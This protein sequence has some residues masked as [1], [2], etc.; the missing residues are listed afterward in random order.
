VVK[1]I[2]YCYFSTSGPRTSS[3]LQLWPFAIKSLD[4]HDYFAWWQASTQEWVWPFVIRSLDTPD[5]DHFVWWK[6]VQ[7][8]QF[9]VNQG[10]HVLVKCI[11]V[12]IRLLPTMS[13]EGAEN[14]LSAACRHAS[15][16]ANMFTA[17]WG[18]QEKYR[19]CILNASLSSECFQ[20]KA[21]HKIYPSVCST[22]NTA[23]NSLLMYLINKSGHTLIMIQRVYCTALVVKMVL[24]V[25]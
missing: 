21:H 2:T 6:A 8:S 10:S 24:C 3:Q 20:C 16:P 22:G 14:V 11:A 15:H 5:L 18:W 17:C 7:W 23:Y 9:A 13:E 4:T 12:N 19:H 1:C 25:M